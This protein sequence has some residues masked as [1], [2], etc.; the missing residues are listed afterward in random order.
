MS[1]ADSQAIYPNTFA[2]LKS[3]SLIF[4]SALT[5]PKVAAF[6]VNI[7]SNSKLSLVLL[8]K[9]A[10]TNLEQPPL[11]NTALGI[12]TELINADSEY[13]DNILLTAGDFGLANKDLNSSDMMGQYIR[14]INQMAGRTYDRYVPMTVKS[15]YGIGSAAMQE[16]TI[17]PTNKEQ[18]SLYKDMIQSS[19]KENYPSYYFNKLEKQS[20]SKKKKLSG[21]PIDVQNA[22]RELERTGKK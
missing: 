12:A 14:L 18:G 3:A 2:V 7:I 9:K 5:V 21:L 6:S 17:Y 16:M 11:P 10:A 19:L 15:P 20:R 1:S 4:A 8:C 22:L 13:L